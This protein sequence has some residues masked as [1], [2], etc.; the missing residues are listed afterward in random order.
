MSSYKTQKSSDG[1]IKINFNEGY[2]AVIIPTKDNKF[3]V[4]VSCQIGCAVGCKFCYSGKMGFKRNLTGEE[5]INQVRVAKEI[6]GHDPTSVI[7]MGMGEPLLN[8]ENVLVAG[9]KIQNIFRVSYNRITISTSCVKGLDKLEKVKFNLALSVHSPFD[10]IRK[11]IMPLSLPISK[12]VKS[13]NSYISHGNN[14]KYVMIEYAL[15]S[16]VNDSDKDLNK[17]ISLKWPERSLFNLI[18]FNDIGEMKASS[19]ERLEY[20]KVKIMERGWKCFIR[21]SRGRDIDASCGM[22]GC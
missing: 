1:T 7:F 17:L 8:L 15:I 22:L 10:K 3:A 19:M 11:I 20:F 16:G 9:E 14:K 18:Q 21:G 4:C 2:I 12:V 5:I 13:A 6:V